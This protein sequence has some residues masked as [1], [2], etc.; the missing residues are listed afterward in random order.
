MLIV[1]D[2]RT[3]AETVQAGLREQGLTVSV[4]HTGDAAL[5]LLGS[6]AVDLVLLDLG[7]PGRDGMDI[8]REARQGG[9]HVPIIVLTARSEVDCRVA[10]LKTGADDYIV[11]PFAFTE[12]LARIEA[13][14][15]R[16]RGPERFLRVGDLEIDLL[17]RKAT[18]G[19]RGIELTQREFEL[20]AYL[21]Q[22]AGHVVSR[23]MLARDVWR[24]TSRA[25]PLD[26]VI[27][28]TVSRLRTKLNEGGA[29]DILKT[30]RGVGYVLGES[31]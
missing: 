23:D 9:N 8:L 5:A 4:A 13:V 18:R 26:N 11:K 10:G 25:T 3:L 14:R 20:A 22:H 30:V 2:D 21:A 12:L 1:E 19:A 31:A 16:A 27:D 17:D 24:V 7:L 29:A 15:R 28:V 6:A